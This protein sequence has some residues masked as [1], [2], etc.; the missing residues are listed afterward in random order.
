MADLKVIQKNL[1]PMICHSRH[2]NQEVKLDYV[3]GSYIFGG[4]EV[5]AFEITTNIHYYTMLCDHFE[6]EKS[7]KKLLMA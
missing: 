7:T 5:P 6:Q 1:S 2:M 4:M 3:F